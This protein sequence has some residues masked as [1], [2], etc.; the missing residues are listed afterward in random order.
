MPSASIRLFNPFDLQHGS[1]QEWH[2]K[3]QEVIYYGDSRFRQALADISKSDSRHHLWMQNCLK[4]ELVCEFLL[5]SIKDC[6]IMSFQLFIM[7]YVGM[8]TSLGLVVEVPMVLRSL[9]ISLAAVPNANLPI[10]FDLGLIAMLD[11]GTNDSDFS[12]IVKSYAL[13]WWKGTHRPADSGTLT[14][15]TLE[16]C[17][18][19]HCLGLL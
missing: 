15:K 7:S 10:P 14:A 19:Q 17:L 6:L 9:S 2:R 4:D 13:A 11:S 3:L 5:N 16:R 12:R 18:K 1:D 8:A